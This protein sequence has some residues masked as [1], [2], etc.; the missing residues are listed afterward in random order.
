[1]QSPITL[2]PASTLTYNY[3]GKSILHNV[4]MVSSTEMHQSALMV[5]AKNTGSDSPARQRDP[6][7]EE[8]GGRE[9]GNEWQADR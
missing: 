6:Q 9:G 5:I 7:R 3:G 4:M 2:A 1:M 8:E